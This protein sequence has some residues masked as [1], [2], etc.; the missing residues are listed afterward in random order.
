MHI[1]YLHHKEEIMTYESD[2]NFVVDRHVAIMQHNF[3][4]N[5]YE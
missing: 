1:V 4:H 3:E 2:H 5:K